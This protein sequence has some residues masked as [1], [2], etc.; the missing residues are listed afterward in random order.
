MYI[1]FII[2]H[3]KRPPQWNDI[4]THKHTHT[5]TQLHTHIVALHTRKIYQ[6]NIIISVSFIIGFEKI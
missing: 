3:R 2:F 4:N 5:Q 1:I 6:S